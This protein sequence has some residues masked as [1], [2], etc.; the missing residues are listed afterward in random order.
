MEYT[1]YFETYKDCH[2][3]VS[4]YAYDGSLALELWNETEGPIATITKC[5]GHRG[6]QENESFV[7][8]NNNPGILSFIKEYNLGIETG[9]VSYCGFCA[10]PLIKFNM[11]EINKYVKEEE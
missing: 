8:T 2:L 1:G 10:Y 5:L 9:G 3:T 11:D 4:T 7:D 6:L